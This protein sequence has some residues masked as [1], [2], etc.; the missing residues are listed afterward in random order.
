MFENII[1]HRDITAMLRA[2]L[3]EGR[4]PRSS[5]FFG[6]AYSA[7][8]STALEVARVLTCRE[9]RG[10]WSCECQSCRLQRELT[11]PH[12][13]LLGPRYSDVEIAA[14]AGALLRNRKSATQYLFL[15]AVRKLTR[16]FDPAILDTEDARM[17]GALEKVSRIEEQLFPLEPGS[18]LPP[19]K[20][21]ADMLE[22]IMAACVG[23]SVHARG[24]GL[25]IGQ[26]RRMAAWS[27]LSATDS[28]K[29]AIIENADRMQEGARNALLKLLEEPPAEVTL[30][31]LTTRRAAIIP[32]ILSRM[33]PYAFDQRS[34]E[35]EKEVMT[36][37]FR[38]EAPAAESLRGYFLAWKEINPD[39]LAALSHRFMELVLD[40]GAGGVEVTAEL[41][42]LFPDRRGSKE[43][44]PKEAVVSFLEELTFRFS[45]AR[46]QGGA[47]ADTLEEWVEAVREAFTRLDV[48]NISPQTAVE[49]L[50]YR[51]RDC[52]HRSDPLPGK[53]SGK[54]SR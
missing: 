38:E 37:I 5:L 28:R 30:V 14:C 31:L 16:K 51:M 26:V 48:Y 4:F 46:R 35:E 19:E 29:V 15:R 33:R 6:P 21:L 34:S 23:L 10:E 36:K 17:K 20:E 12:T 3:T 44:S 41:S 43:R 7:K 1:G 40:P 49:A 2:E 54:A 45:E 25:T 24:D 39:K 22:G 50:Y 27:H 32:T 42:E 13:V 11:H 8:L 18:P 53:G 47:A 52:I 9:G